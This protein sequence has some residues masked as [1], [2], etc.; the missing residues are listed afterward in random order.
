M[1]LTPIA[2]GAW[3]TSSSL[4]GLMMATTS[5]MVRPSFPKDSKRR[6]RVIC[7]PGKSG[8]FLCEWH[9]KLQAR[10]KN[11]CCMPLPVGSFPVRGTDNPQ[12]CGFV[13]GGP[14]GPRARST[15]KGDEMS[16]RS[17]FFASQGQQQGPYPEA[18]LR[19]FIAKG[20]VTADTL[21]W[22]EGMAD[23]QKAGD[24]P[25]L[26]SA[27]PRPPAFARSGAPLTGTGSQDG[28]P[29]SIDV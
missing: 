8:I 12:K 28:G 6:S 13:T 1:P 27:T 25:G 11:N 20:T 4:N 22:S 21:V 15:P 17:W 2:V 7:G 29:L 14:S 23:W 18:Q 16:N 10:A 3:R 19:E 9:K 24:I 26:L 5:F